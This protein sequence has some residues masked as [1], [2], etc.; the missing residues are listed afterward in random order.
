MRWTGLVEHARP[1]S[2]CTP[3]FDFSRSEACEENTS[4]SID[5]EVIWVVVSNIF[6]VSPLPAGKW[7]SLTNIFQLGWNPPTSD[8]WC[9]VL[10]VFLRDTFGDKVA[11][12][13]R[14]HTWT[15]KRRNQERSSK[16]A[17]WRAL[18]LWDV[19]LWN[20]YTMTNDK[21]N[22]AGDLDRIFIFFFRFLGCGTQLYLPNEGIWMN[23]I[24]FGDGFIGQA[25]CSSFHPIG[26]VCVLIFRSSSRTSCSICAP[27]FCGSH[28]VC[29]WL[30]V[31][32]TR[33]QRSRYIHWVVLQWFLV[34]VL[35]H[36]HNQQY[37]VQCIFGLTSSGECMI[38]M[39]VL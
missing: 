37:V 30:C 7:S 28:L 36:P 13:P 4:W 6:W 27:S 31:G 22:S 19:G 18:I 33:L 35:W 17:R 8:E 1:R 24:Y 20:F 16:I 32:G 34:R 12:P 2:A 3:D 14:L 15:K 39:H 9:W 29:T 10:R 11:G 25:F 23:L 26:K 21:S 5:F 38:C